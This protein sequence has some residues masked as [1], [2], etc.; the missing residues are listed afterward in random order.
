[1][2]AAK[3]M[4]PSV[5]WIISALSI[6]AWATLSA[7]SRLA[8]ADHATRVAM[9]LIATLLLFVG[10]GSALNAIDFKRQHKAA[11]AAPRRATTSE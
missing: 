3:A 10:F 5:Y 6:A 4:W 7:A 1:M 9:R 8:E 11:A 2:N